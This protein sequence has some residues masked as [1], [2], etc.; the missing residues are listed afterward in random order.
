M[1][2]PVPVVILE[3]LTEPEAVTLGLTRPQTRLQHL[4]PT[5]RLP[6]VALHI[7]AAALLA[8]WA[9]L[10]PLALVLQNTQAVTAVFRKLLPQI[11]ARLA[12]VRRRTILAMV[13]PAVAAEPPTTEPA[14]AVAQERAVM[15][16]MAELPKTARA[17]RVV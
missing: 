14:V 1:A 2:L 5:V 7:P 8:V 13:I 11:M 3:P 9:A 15:A 16:L 6:R 10:L 12:V 4:R 17:V